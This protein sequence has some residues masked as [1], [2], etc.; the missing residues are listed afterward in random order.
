MFYE[1]T[2]NWIIGL[3]WTPWHSILIVVQ[4]LLQVSTIRLVGLAIREIQ[5]VKNVKVAIYFGPC[6]FSIACVDVYVLLDLLEIVMS[7]SNQC[8]VSTVSLAI[9]D[10]WYVNRDTAAVLS[11]PCFVSFPGVEYVHCEP[12]H[13]WPHRGLDCDANKRSLHLHQGLDIWSCCVPVL[14]WYRLHSLHGLHPQLIHP[15]L[16]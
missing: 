13:C 15:Q 4:F 8:F 14:D 1:Y 6:Y 3:M 12:C 2:V 9:A 11:N 16:R 10:L 7:H 5:Y